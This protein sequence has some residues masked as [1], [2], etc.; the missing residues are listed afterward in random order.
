MYRV[1]VQVQATVAYN[2]VALPAVYA[3]KRIMSFLTILLHGWGK[4]YTLHVCVLVLEFQ[5]AVK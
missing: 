2:Q 4:F 3:G 5:Q 1:A